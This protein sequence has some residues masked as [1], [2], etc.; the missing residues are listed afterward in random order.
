VVE[1]NTNNSIMLGQFAR[2]ILAGLFVIL[3]LIIFLFLRRSYKKVA[4]PVKIISENAE[5]AVVSK[6]GNIRKVETKIEEFQKLD[7]FSTYLI[8]L[9]KQRGGANPEMVN[10]IIEVKEV[11]GKYKNEKLERDANKFRLAVDG[12]LDLVAIV[13]THGYLTYVNKALTNLTGIKPSD[14]ENKRITDLWHPNDDLNMWKQNFEKVVKEKKP[15]QFSSWGVKQN[16]IK[17]ESN[18]QISPIITDDGFIENLLVVERDV[19]EEK[20][21]ERIKSEFISVVSHEL[22]TPMTS[23]NGYIDLMNR[24]LIQ[25]KAIE[26]TWVKS[27]SNE[28][29]RLT[30]LIEE[31]LEVNKVKSGKL[32]FDFRNCH[33]SDVITQAI[34]R[35]KFTFPT[36]KIIYTNKVTQDVD[37]VRGDFNKL[38]QAFNNLLDNAAKHSSVDKPIFINYLY[39]KNKLVIEIQDSGKGIAP[40][41]IP[42]VFK[43]F[44]KAED[45]LKEGMGLGLYITKN[46]LDKHNAA[47]KVTSELNKGTTFILTFHPQK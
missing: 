15:L 11:E 8:D 24:R 25:N 40:H 39:I 1:A 18:I 4:K 21:K 36:H 26:N 44:Y 6:W 41:D 12:A 45:N 33:L 32:V 46:I 35:F 17:F 13:D 43:V 10:K 20:Q 29:S 23:I 42:N 16:G 27:L 3:L 19:T 47:I 28:A 34:H 9:L 14:A 37:T 22:R 30:H 2:N 5:N 7:K 38:L 31:L